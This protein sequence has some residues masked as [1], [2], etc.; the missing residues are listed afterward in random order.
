MEGDQQENQTGYENQWN[1]QQDYGTQWQNQNGYYQNQTGYEN[2]WNGQ[3][4]Y[5]TP[6]QNQNGY[7]QNQTGYENQWNTQQNY[8]NQWNM[9]TNAGQMYGQSV[10]PACGTPLL[11]GMCPRCTSLSTIQQQ[12]KNDDR[13]K[14]FFSNPN[15]KLI[16]TLGNSYIQNYFANGSIS[17]GFAV[18]SNRR[19]YFRGTSYEISYDNR[20][21][22]RVNKTARSRIVDLKDITGTGYDSTRVV[23]YLWS[24]WIMLIIALVLAIMVGNNITM[25]EYGSSG[26]HSYSYNSYGISQSGVRILSAVAIVL[27]F[28]ALIAFFAYF[29]SRLTLISIQYAGGEIAFNVNWFPQAEMDDFQKQ[30]RLAKD[31]LMDQM[32]NRGMM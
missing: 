22:K 6:W 5:G 29:R 25:T 4:N 1:D 3:Q 32:M 14:R 13:F 18:V 11:N 31:N 12:N 26:Y 27:L 16:T 28:G 21:K 30:L 23:S 8:D 10:C 20:G 2:Q 19:A 24:G 15:E 17:R 9:Q 7:Y